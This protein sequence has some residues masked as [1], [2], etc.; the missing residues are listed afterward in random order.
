MARV[1]SLSIYAQNGSSKEFLAEQYGAVIE[2]IQ[3]GTIS[4]EL[5]N[6][7]LSGSPTAG[8]VEAK[9]FVNA[10]VQ[11]Y[12]TARAGGAGAKVKAQTVTVVI[13][14]HREIIEEVNDDDVAMY[15]V[16]GLIER[17]TANHKM[18][19]AKD[20][21]REFFIEAAKGTAATL[22][23][24]DEIA[25]VDEAITTLEET[26]NEFVDGIDRMFMTIVAR[27]TFYTA[28]QSEI[29]TLSNPNVN[30]AAGEIK[31]FHGCKIKKSTDLPEGVKFI[32][33]TDGAVAQPVRFNIS[34]LEPI[35]MSQDWSF[36]IFYTFG[37]KAVAPD[38]VL[39]VK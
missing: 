7:E 28:L 31:E 23:A 38:T 1:E 20:L 10:A 3:T 15:G 22:E 13:D 12:G 36:G 16:E 4:G 18:R 8:S 33:Y 34:P 29:D 11:T 24:T 19:I 6:R 2:N 21:E 27:P 30:S 14:Q 26:K 39:V 32:V 5:K 25:M 37:T 17:R 35:P 9:R